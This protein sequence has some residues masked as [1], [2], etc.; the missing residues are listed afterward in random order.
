MSIKL[1]AALLLGLL[2]AGLTVAASVPNRFVVGFMVIGAFWFALQVWVLRPLTSDGEALRK[3]MEDRARIGRD[4]HDGVI[5]SLYAAGIGLAGVRTL[6]RP[7][8]TEATARL[9]QSRTA[10]SEAIHDVRNVLA[11]LEPEALKSRTFAEAIAV[12]CETMGGIRPFRSRVEIDEAMAARLSL[13]QRGHALQIT[14]EAVGNALRH[15]KANLVGV[16]LGQRN[17]RV[18]FEV[19]DDGRGFDPGMAASPGAGL[20]NFAQRARELGAELTVQSEPGRGAHVKLTFSL[21]PL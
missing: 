3:S 5:Q 16:S 14:R 9:D 4:L 10:L 7:E 12:L 1:R 21:P 18:E 19:S 20:A 13:S 11:G 2:V 15:G 17:G 8:Q 6:L